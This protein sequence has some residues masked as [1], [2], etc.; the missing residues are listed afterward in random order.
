MPAVTVFSDFC[1]PFNKNRDPTK[2]T[3]TISNG[4]DFAYFL[5]NK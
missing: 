4:M 3:K 1:D 2:I 5:E